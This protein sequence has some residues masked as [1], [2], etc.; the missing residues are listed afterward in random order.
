MMTVREQ[1]A[2]ASSRWCVVSKQR[3][4]SGPQI[5]E[6]VVNALAALRIDAGSRLVEQNDARAMNDATGDVEAA[7][8][9]AG[10]LL[11]RLCGAIGEA[12]SIQH[13]V[14]LAFES[15]AAKSLQTAKCQQVF[16]R[17]QKRIE[18]DFLGHDAEL[19][20]CFA[21]RERTIE[22]SNLSA[23]ETNAA[24][25]GANERRLARAIRSEERQQLALGER[26]GCAVERFHLAKGFAGVR[27]S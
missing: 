26:E 10:E 7:L 25:D 17:G 19:G 2:S 1:R 15:G 16:A 14:D 24:A 21:A 12:D 22:Q 9:A 11:D 27:D 3:N 13:P 18:R 4:A 20:R 6:D 8:H 5:V 23:I